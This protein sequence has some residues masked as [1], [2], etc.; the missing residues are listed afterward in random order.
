MPRVVTVPGEEA[1]SEDVNT[2]SDATV[3]RF[4]S[5]AQRTGQWPAPFDGALSHL[6]DWHTIDQ[7]RDGAWFTI[8]RVDPAYV[9]SYGTTV[10]PNLRVGYPSEPQFAGLSNERHAH[11]AL[12]G[13]ALTPGGTVHGRAS[14]SDLGMSVEVFDG[15]TRIESLLI[16]LR[17]EFAVLCDQLTSNPSIRLWE[18]LNGDVRFQVAQG[19][20]VHLLLTDSNATF[21]EMDLHITGNVLAQNIPANLATRL[22]ALELAAGIVAT[23][24]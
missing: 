7:Y 12:L 22:E 19:E 5:E 14:L 23:D 6:L 18:D 11:A 1:L 10:V 21:G 16:A 3:H 17:Y 4:D 13:G 9:N 8:A 2:I 15:S 20:T 24:E